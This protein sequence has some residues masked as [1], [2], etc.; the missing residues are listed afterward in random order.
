[1]P[2]DGPWRG[3]DGVIDPMAGVERVRVCH[4]ITSLST[5]GA[6]AQLERLVRHVPAS[7]L[8]VSLRDLGAVGSRLRERGVLVHALELTHRATWL[9][10]LARMRKLIRQYDADVVQGWMYHG[11]LAATAAVLGTRIPLCWNVRHSVHGLEDEPRQTRRA[12]RASIHFSRKPRVIVYNS[13]TAAVQHEELGYP[14]GA[15][16]VIP[17]GFDVD[18]LRRDTRAGARFRAQT[19][20]GATAPVVGMVARYHPM[21]NHE[22]FIRMAERLAA[23]RPDVVF[24]MAG[25]GVDWENRALAGAAGVELLQGRIHLLG[26]RQDLLGLYNAL[27]VLC[28]ASGWG[29]AFPNVVAEAMACEIPCVVTD[30]GDSSSVVGESGLTVRPRD[31]QGLVDAVSSLLS[32]QRRC[33]VLGEAARERIE[34]T[35]DIGLVADDYARLWSPCAAVRAQ[36]EPTA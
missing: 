25:S 4:V 6:Q 22:G 31:E 17:N 27:D 35:Y 11:N 9:G 2:G 36:V 8:V 30:V 26:E 5:G 28:C 33:R 32:D 24:V 7:H 3:S 15:R 14:V 19:G 10:G 16:Q 18:A 21:K 23:A 13:A 34:A 12:I 29:E 20:I 1:M